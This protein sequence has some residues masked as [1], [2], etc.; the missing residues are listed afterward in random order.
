MVVAASVYTAITTASFAASFINFDKTVSRRNGFFQDISNRV[1]PEVQPAFYGEEEPLWR[2]SSVHHSRVIRI[3]QATCSQATIIMQ[4]TSRILASI[5]GEIIG[6]KS[7]KIDELAR[8]SDCAISATASSRSE[9]IIYAPPPDRPKSI[10]PW[11]PQIEYSGTQ[12]I[13][14]SERLMLHIRRPGRSI[15]D[16]FNQDKSK[17]F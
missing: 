2:F 5:F 11:P 1:H 16:Q 17:T 15:K 13:A 10:S 4:A 3:Q 9:Q 7:S 14:I 8:S 12:V 6:S